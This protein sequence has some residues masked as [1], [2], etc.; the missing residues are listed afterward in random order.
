[1]T[2]CEV[3]DKRDADGAGQMINPEAKGVVTT[4]RYW[5]DNWL[6]SRRRQ[7]CW[8]HPRRD[9]QALVE[10]GGET[11]VTGEA[12]LGQGT[13]LFK[14]WHQAR[15]GDLRRERLQTGMRPV[16]R[17]VKRLLEAGAR[18]QQPKTRRTCA[19]RR[20]VSVQLGADENRS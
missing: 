3:F 20:V 17:E 6:P 13:R 7:V 11:A 10:R 5:S 2:A 12:L 18:R 16:R 9:F 15:D 4:D 8:A 1:M 14:L 19:L